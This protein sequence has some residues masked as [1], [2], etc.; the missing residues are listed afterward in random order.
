MRRLAQKLHPALPALAATVLALHGVGTAFASDHLDGPA[1]AADPQADIGDLYAWT[2][3]NGRQL[4]L[5]MTLVG[6]TFSDK[7]SY[8]FHVDSGP[9]FNKT[10]DTITIACHFMSVA[11]AAAVE[12]VAADAIRCDAGDLDHAKGNASSEAGLMS[13]RGRFR[14]FAGL[15]DDP[16][17]N[18]VRGSRD[19]FSVAAAAIKGGAPVDAG[20]CPQFDAETSKTILSRWRATD[21]GP[22]RNFL[23]GWTSSALVI[24]IDLELVQRGGKML[25]VWGDTSSPQRRIDRIGRPLTGNALL[26]PL[27]PGEVSN[28]LK[29][30]YNEAT[31][32]T[33]VKFIPAI[34]KSLGYYDGYDGKC[35]N[36]LLAAPGAASANRYH[37]LATLLADDRLWV[38]S[39]SSTCTQLFG[40]ELAHLAGRTA[41]RK[42]CGGRT[43][44]Y[45]ASNIF[46]S[47]LANGSIA[48]IDDGL[49][50]DDSEHSV[51]V[52]PFLAAP[53]VTRE[54]GR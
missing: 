53:N 6:K 49:H 13:A 5:V 1:V 8:R 25:A 40:V 41:L 24:A 39:E 28:P 34:Q 43:P 17:F 29:I 11:A 38:N 37:A 21:G 2:S 14:V 52:F 35:G 22:A 30:E 45:N 15:R 7:L 12:A 4:N 3:T 48:G 36:Q 42:D 54:Y 44:N 46:R 20:G 9:Q 33:A 19:A 26:E 31:P 47:L 10:T 18:N 16:F 27:S 50:N 32:A 51:S 23:A